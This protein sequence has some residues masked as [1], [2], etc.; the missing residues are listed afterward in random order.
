MDYRKGEKSL[1]VKVC[2]CASS[3]AIG[4]EAP[5]RSHLFCTMRHPPTFLS[6]QYLLCHEGSPGSLILSVEVFYYAQG[7]SVS[8]MLRVSGYLR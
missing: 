5:D 1:Q 2:P 8:I 6:S 4:Q 7:F 3:K